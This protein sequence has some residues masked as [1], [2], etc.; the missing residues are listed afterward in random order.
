M[1]KIRKELFETGA[2]LLLASAEIMGVEGVR[3]DVTSP[4]QINV[5]TYSADDVT[6]NSVNITP[7]NLSD[8]FTTHGSSTIDQGIATLTPDE[9][10]MVGNVTLNTKIDLSQDFTLNGMVKLG[11]KTKDKGGG[12]GIGFVFQPGD[13]G[14]VGGN[15]QYLGLGGLPNAFG[16]K[17]D[18]YYNGLSGGWKAPNGTDPFDPA[19]IN[20]LNGGN[21]VQNGDTNSAFADFMSTDASGNMSTNPTPGGTPAKEIPLYPQ[22]E[23][24][25]IIYTASSHTLTVQYAGISGSEDISS[26][27]PA[28]GK[29]SFSITGSTGGNFNLQQV[30]INNFSYTKAQGTVTVRYEDQNGNPIADPK[31]LTGDV[32]SSFMATPLANVPGK[33]TLSAVRGDKGGL[34]TA[35]DQEVIFVYN[36]DYQVSAPH[37]VTETVKYVDENGKVLADPASQ[38]V[39]VV[40]VT[41]PVSGNKTYYFKQGDQP[42]PTTDQYG[43]L[44]NSWSVGGA[45]L[46]AIANPAVADYHVVSTTDPAN[47]LTQT[48]AQKVDDSSKDLNFTVTYAHDKGSVTVHAVDINGNVLLKTPI[49]ISGNDGD[50]YTTT[51][52]AIPNYKLVQT[53]GNNKG[54]Y[55]KSS[56]DV[57]YV[58]AIDYKVSSSQV[59]NE[60]IHYTDKNGNKLS[61]DYK[62]NVSFVTVTNPVTGGETVYYKAGDNKK[63]EVDNNGLPDNTWTKSD[64][65]TFEAVTNPTIDGYHVVSTT[66]KDSNLTETAEK[67]A[68]ANS[69]D[70]SIDVVYAKDEEEVIPPVNPSE[71]TKPS[72]PAKPAKPAKPEQPAQPVKPEQ[73]VRPEQPVK[74]EQPVN[75]V[76]PA[77]PEQPAKSVQP[78]NSA[79]LGQTAKGEARAF[80]LLPRTGERSGLLG[81]VIGVG[82]LILAALGLKR[83]TD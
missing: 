6:R 9:P 81:V 24:F 34:F 40:S 45:S 62:N 7:A 37:V 73:P 61:D 39:T 80:S 44:D 54:I 5:D 57:T 68:S 55:S 66:D 29:V 1:K 8:Y 48:T 19:V 20:G 31:V 12:D 13:T 78:A 30:E 42:A 77:L 58:Y 60:T 38:K 17:L 3:A 25:N 75:P 11:T 41:D 59:I 53:L 72:K 22:F 23:S 50:T 74:P 2:A 67:Q 70:L 4:K 10:N 52:P 32:G 76:K 71:P 33:Y 26:L 16:F 18:T 65:F 79:R 47:D 35:D 46:P 28:S 64:Q 49:T 14:N 43:K 56:Q 83:K 63:P 21:V 69:K 15:G 51:A 82:V 36:V 27:I